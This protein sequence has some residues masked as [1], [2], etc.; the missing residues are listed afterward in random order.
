MNVSASYEAMNLQISDPDV[1]ADN[2]RQAVVDKLAPLLPSAKDVVDAVQQGILEDVDQHVK[3]LLEPI[4]LPCTA[5][6]TRGAAGS[7]GPTGPHS[8]DGPS[9]LHGNDGP[10]GPHGVDGP[11]RPHGADGCPS[12]KGDPGPKGDAGP[13]GPQGPPG[14]PGPSSSVTPPTTNTGIDWHDCPVD[15]G[16]LEGIYNVTLDSIVSWTFP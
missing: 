3:D 14:P 2:T 4:Q 9:G 1:I 7:T 11:P 5:T 13:E 15:P 16:T 10:P 8:R 6:G 12:P